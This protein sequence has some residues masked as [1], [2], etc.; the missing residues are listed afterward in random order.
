MSL[1]CNKCFTIFIQS[2]VESDSACPIEN[3]GGITVHI[4]DEFVHVVSGLNKKGF[5]TDFCCAGHYAHH[6]CYI[7]FNIS[8][9]EEFKRLGS[10]V[11][12]DNKQSSI[13]DV[14]AEFLPKWYGL[15]TKFRQNN[16]SLEFDEYFG[17]FRIVARN[18]QLDCYD[19]GME[20]SSKRL[21]KAR[22]PFFK[23]YDDLN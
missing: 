20:E 4:D 22:L 16:I 13:E 3:C 15:I 23:V 7:L 9:S 11:F 10:N 18:G 1:M 21:F 17:D 5:T 19:L 12:I 8:R 2:R 14:I 6:T